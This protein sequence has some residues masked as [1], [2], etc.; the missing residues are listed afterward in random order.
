QAVQSQQVISA[1]ATPA[2]VIPA[3]EADKL[4]DNKQ[5]VTSPMVGTFY[6]ASSPTASPFAEI[7]KQIKIGQVLC[8]I[9]A[10]KLMNQIESD[11]EGIIKEI[12][13]KDGAPVEFGQQ[14]FVIE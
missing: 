8:I 1:T 3:V 5:Y 14:L 2:T 4:P 10:M 11:K 13:V 6:R 12:L 7:G 9:E